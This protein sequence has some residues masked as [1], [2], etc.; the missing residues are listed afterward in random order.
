MTRNDN[1]QNVINTLFSKNY[2]SPIIFEYRNTIYKVL[3]IWMKC[4][5]L[6]LNNKRYKE[7]KDELS[8]NWEI[9][10]QK[11]CQRINR[12][13]EWKI[14]EKLWDSCKKKMPTAAMWALLNDIYV[15]DLSNYFCI[16]WRHFN[17]LYNCRRHFRRYFRP[18]TW[19]NKVKH[20]FKG[21]AAL[22]S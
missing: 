15:E 9:G 7:W 17:R 3:L 18:L 12:R 10:R 22:G 4:P 6:F 19:L 11:Y 21:L 5:L 8:T 16:S 13:E 1:T 14:R 20:V 2:I